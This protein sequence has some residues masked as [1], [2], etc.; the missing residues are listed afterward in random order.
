MRELIEIRNDLKNYNLKA[1]SRE[2]GLHANSLYNLM[3][4][5]GQP[6]YETVKKVEEFLEKGKK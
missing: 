3:N 2:T 1:V 4:G 6:K 5:E